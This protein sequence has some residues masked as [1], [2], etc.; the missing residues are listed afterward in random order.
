MTQEQI[1]T[2]LAKNHR[3]T[4]FAR[5]LGIT[6]QTFGTHCHADAKKH[7]YNEQFR[8]YLVEVAKTR[9]IK[10]LKHNVS[11]AQKAHLLRIPKKK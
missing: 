1:Y 6:R 10:P 3:M 9:G 2:L 7:D 5:F 8:D 4:D 11:K